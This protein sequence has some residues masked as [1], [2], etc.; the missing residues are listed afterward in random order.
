MASSW[1]LLECGFDRVRRS[2]IGLLE[3]MAVAVHRRAD[4]RMSN[5]PG[6]CEWV[7]AARDQRADMTVAQSME[8][9]PGQPVPAHEC[10]PLPAQPIGVDRIAVDGAEH[11]RLGIGPPL[12]E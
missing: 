11:Q 1:P 12:P 7:D 2:S 9:H 8:G 3:H 6:D 4:V 10:T 5:A